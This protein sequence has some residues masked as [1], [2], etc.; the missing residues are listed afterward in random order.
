MQKDVIDQLRT[1][2]ANRSN[3]AKEAGTNPDLY[4]Q[5]HMFLMMKETKKSLE[6]PGF[7]PVQWIG[8]SEKLKIGGVEYVVV[9]RPYLIK[10][11][12]KLYKED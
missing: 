5:P 7:K 1:D 11:L 2:M 8:P 12:A 3:I 9:L 4:Q 10:F 6:D